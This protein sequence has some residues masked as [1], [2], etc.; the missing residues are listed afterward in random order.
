MADENRRTETARRHDD[1]H[2]SGG[3]ET[4]EEQGRA[5]GDLQTDVATQ[6]TRERVDD[7]DAHEG[8]TKEDELQYTG[9]KGGA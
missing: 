2:L 5:G 4:P 6:A 8:V 7:P 1:S 3:P 9:R